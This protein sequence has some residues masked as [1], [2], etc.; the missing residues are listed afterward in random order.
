MKSDVRDLVEVLEAALE[1]MDEF[2]AHGV[3][4]DA[5]KFFAERLQTTD[6][7]RALRES[8]HTAAWI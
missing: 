8:L 5:F 1:R 2:G 3:M 6:G 7:S 4:G